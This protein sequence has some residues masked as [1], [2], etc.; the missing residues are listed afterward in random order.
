MREVFKPATMVWHG[1]KLKILCHILRS[2]CMNKI[3]DETGWWWQLF[4][5]PAFF[6]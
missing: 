4:K 3:D 5:D 6:V 1:Q 2:V